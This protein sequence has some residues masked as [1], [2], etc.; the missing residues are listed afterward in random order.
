MRHIGVKLMTSSSA[1]GFEKLPFSGVARRQDF[2]HHQS[3][4]AVQVLVARLEDFLFH[5]MGT[6]LSCAE[7]KNKTF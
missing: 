4:L 6:E 3:F 1:R 7:I 5:I 2:H